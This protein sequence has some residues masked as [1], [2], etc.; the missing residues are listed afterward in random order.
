MVME[1]MVTEVILGMVPTDL[2]LLV[3]ILVADGV[4][5]DWEEDWEEAAGAAGVEVEELGALQGLEERER[6][7]SPNCETKN[8][9]ILF[10]VV[11]LI[12]LND[13]ALTKYQS[14]LKLSQKSLLIDFSVSDFTKY[15]EKGPRDF[16]LFVFFTSETNLFPCPSCK[17]LKPEIEQTAKWYK[18]SLK[19]KDQPEIFFAVIELQKRKEIFE[20]NQNT[21]KQLPLFVYFPPTSANNIKFD[22]KMEDVLNIQ[23]ETLSAELVGEFIMRKT[24]IKFDMEHPIDLTLFYYGFTVLIVLAMLLYRLPKILLALRSPIIWFAGIFVVIF[25]SY[26]GF[27]FNYNTRPPFNY[28][29][30]NKQTIWFYPNLRHQFVAEGLIMASGVLFGS[31]SIVML[32]IFI[33]QIK[34]GTR[35][36]I[37][38]AVAL[39]VTVATFYYV[40]QAFG[41]K[42]KG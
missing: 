22:I 13:S 1:D 26:A 29:D 2:L 15:L 38:F 34:R 11:S 14:I 3:P 28:K 20:R 9:V 27:V 25:I 36:R 17:A 39:I 23:V 6:A 4:E 35:R 5:E 41:L 24:K 30:Q 42:L 32:G 21:I 18:D 37:S 19:N 10:V 16:H 31:I 12:G 8:F 7:N 40:G 33:P